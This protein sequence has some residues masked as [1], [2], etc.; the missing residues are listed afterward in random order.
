MPDFQS[1]RRNL[2]DEV[3]TMRANIAWA[4]LVVA[5][6]RVGYLL[7]KRFN[8]DQPRV[9]A[10]RPDGGQWTRVGEGDARTSQDGLVDISDRAE[11]PDTALTDPVPITADQYAAAFRLAANAGLPTMGSASEF[12]AAV[13]AGHLHTSFSN[14]DGSISTMGGQMVVSGPSGRGFIAA[15]SPD[16][17]LTASF[18][19]DPDGN[20]I[21]ID[22]TSSFRI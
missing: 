18:M 7:H 16:E 8:P 9:P 13:V 10:G 12:G 22:V 17:I 6:L 11:L 3:A 19:K 2:P 20:I 4:G 1:R 5:G 21:G 14:P 15:T